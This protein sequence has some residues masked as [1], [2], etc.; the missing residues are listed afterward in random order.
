M[1]I[2]RFIFQL[3]GINTY[4]V[5][6][7][8]THCAAV[9]DPGMMTEKEENALSS[10]IEKNGLKVTNLINTHMHID[11][12]AGNDFVMKAYQVNLSAHPLEKELGAMLGNQAKMFQLDFEPEGS[13]ITT[14]LNDGDVVKIGDGTLKVLHV[15]GHSPG[16]IALYSE[17]DGFLISGDALFANSI[18]RTDLMG[19]SMPQ[20]VNAIK[21]KLLKLPDE[22]VVYPGHG[23]PTTIGWEKEHN[24]YLR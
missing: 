12:A 24:P 1:K 8:D 14:Y 2:V 9:V 23:D 21:T 22:T 6:N 7:E 20:L 5:W 3:F 13:E 18:G 19:G 10:F 11:H 4:V 17:K 15:P 16:S